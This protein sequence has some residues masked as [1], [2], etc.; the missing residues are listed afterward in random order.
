AATTVKTITSPGPL[1]PK[2]PA[3]FTTIPTGA[4][5]PRPSIQFF[6]P[7]FQNPEVHQAS[8]GL[9]RALAHDVSVAVSYLFVAGRKLALS[10]D[11]NVG[12]AVP[13]AIPIQGGGSLTID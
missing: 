3:V 13:T 5:L 1:L 7:D 4:A 6:D 9:E 8:V 10:R 2:Y 12:D 11:F